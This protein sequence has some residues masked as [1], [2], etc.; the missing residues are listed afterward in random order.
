MNGL[1]LMDP[2]PVSGPCHYI[3][4][5]AGAWAVGTQ[6]LSWISYIELGHKK[7]TA[8]E[9]WMA[10]LALAVGCDGQHIM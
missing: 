2:L 4:L 3:T 9:R 1:I 7:S 6:H 5:F 10:K 8:L